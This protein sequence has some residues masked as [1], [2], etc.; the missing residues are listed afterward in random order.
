M[1]REGRLTCPRFLSQ[2]SAELKLEPGLILPA[3][4]SIYSVM[5]IPRK[6]EKE[7]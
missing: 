2:L 1:S 6:R 3:H 5:L 7:I 4:C